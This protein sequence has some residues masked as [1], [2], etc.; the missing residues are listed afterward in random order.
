MSVLVQ[1]QRLCPVNRKQRGILSACIECLSECIMVQVIVR[2]FI[3]E[4]VVC[5]YWICA[6]LFDWSV[7]WLWKMAP[8]S[9]A[10]KNDE[11]KEADDD[12]RDVASLKHQ[13]AT[14]TSSL[15]TL[16]EQKSKMEAVYL[17]EK[18]KM[19]VRN[20]DYAV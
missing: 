11:D 18:R 9:E 2:L 1:N 3:R 13:L 15:Y 17:S 16:T 4:R 19:K 20:G 5:C 10:K 7:L 8:L 6:V 12:E 14:L